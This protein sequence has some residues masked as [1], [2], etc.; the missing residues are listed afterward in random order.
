MPANQYIPAG[1][2]SLVDKAGVPLHVQTEYA[3]RPYPRVTTT[4][5]DHGRV[6]HKVEKKLSKGIDS[7]EEQCQMEEVIK[8]QHG[9]IVAII[10]NN[11]G[12]AV[13]KNEQS[14]TQKLKIVS[15]AA[16]ADKLSAIPG[17]ERVYQLDREGK[18]SD[19]EEASVFKSAYPTLFKGLCE[20]AKMFMII[21]G[22]EMKREQGVFEIEPD[23]LYFVSAGNEYFFVKAERA[24]FKT[25][26]EK[27]IKE[28]ISPDGHL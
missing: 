11:Q 27:A 9:E 20:M 28:I 21:P 8:Q 1:R 15:E 6:L 22:A 24:D 3:Y 4:I 14:E 18:F 7:H 25:D 26:F 23:R 5:L 2:T 10:K 13:P 17:V 19:T 12:K 16:T